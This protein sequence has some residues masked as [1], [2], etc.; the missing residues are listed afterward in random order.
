MT[1]KRYSLFIATFS[2]KLG[3]L[4]VF[5][6]KSEYC[7]FIET[8]CTGFNCSIIIDS[9]NSHENNFTIEKGLNI[10]QIMKFSMKNPSKRGGID[11]Y[12]II[13]KAIKGLG[14]IKEDQLKKIVEDLKNFIIS[15]NLEPSFEDFKTFQE[16]WEKVLQDSF[17]LTVLAEKHF[18]I[19]ERLN[20]ISGYLQILLQDAKTKKIEKDAKIINE[21]LDSVFEIEDILS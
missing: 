16:K 12:L 13:T 21:I 6:Q 8:N 20:I 4:C 15:K 19:R 1:K 17:N 7:K 11:K 14:N 3:P 18:Y 2:N 5:A 9:V 10:F